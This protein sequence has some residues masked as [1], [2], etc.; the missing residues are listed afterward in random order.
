MQFFVWFILWT[1]RQ[2]IGRAQKEI[3]MQTYQWWIFI[4]YIQCVE[5]VQLEIRTRVTV[6]ISFQCE[7]QHFQLVIHSSS[8]FDD[9]IVRIERFIAFADALIIVAFHFVQQRWMS[10][11]ILIWAL[12]QKRKRIMKSFHKQ[13][14]I[15]YSL[16]SRPVNSFP[17]AL[18]PNA[19]SCSTIN[20][21]KYYYVVGIFSCPTNSP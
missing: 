17:A 1:R 2:L 18:D 6:M 4:N 8:L 16:I 9:H 13:I 7:M 21:R 10:R 5:M 15:R 19:A 14:H 11:R 12:Y 20:D 3:G